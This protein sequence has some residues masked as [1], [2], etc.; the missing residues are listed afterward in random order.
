MIIGIVRRI[1]VDDSVIGI[2][3]KVDIDAIT[4]LARMGYID[5]TA[6]NDVF[7]MKMPVSKELLEAVTPEMLE[8]VM[9]GGG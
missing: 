1:H 4:P 5:Y 8:K 3:G 2:D 6:V 9:S 7:S